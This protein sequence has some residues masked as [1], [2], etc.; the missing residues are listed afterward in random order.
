MHVFRCTLSF[1][2]VNKCPVKYIDECRT[3]NIC[4]PREKCTN[5]SAAYVCSCAKGYESKD[6][7]KLNCTDIDECITR[8]SNCD[9][10]SYCSNTIGSFGCTC[11]EGFKM[12]DEGS[13]EESFF[14]IED[15]SGICLHHPIIPLA[16]VLLTW[17]TLP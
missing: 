16:F 13:C 7:N 14:F 17:L 1:D 15:S 9:P 10:N 2:N 11:K 3:L 5:K 6:K 8:R 4:G 12:S